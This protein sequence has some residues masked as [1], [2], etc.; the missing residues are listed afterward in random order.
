[1]KED[2]SSNIN[3]IH[4]K[5]SV[6]DLSQDDYVIECIDGS[7]DSIKYRDIKVIIMKNNGYVNCSKLCKMRN[8]YFSRWLRLSTS[9]ALLDIYNNK[10]V[11][12]AIVKVYGKGKKLIITGFYLKQNMI[13]YV[14]EWIGDDF[15]NDIYKMINF[16]NA[17]FGNDELK[18]VSCENTLCPFIE[19]GR[20]YYGKKCKYIHGDQCDICGLYILHPTDINQRVSHKKTCLVDRDSLIV[21]KRST[22]KKCG[23]CIEEINKKHI[24]EQY[25]GILPSCK[26]IFCLSCIRRWADTTRN[27]DTENTCPECRIVFPFIIP[28]RYWIDNKY[29]KKILYNRYKKMI[30][31]KIPIR[32][33]KI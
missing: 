22:S 7:F 29:D 32:T 28:S 13:R 11:D 1:M 12:N 19:L 8:K 24:S 23:V 31:T 10:S 3:N 6:S 26:H 9:K 5:Y 18:I 15:T 2:D 33:I 25:F 17:L 21:F 30:F 27:T 20:C 16:Y 4:G 14:I